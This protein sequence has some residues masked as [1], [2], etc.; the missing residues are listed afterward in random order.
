MWRRASAYLLDRVEPPRQLVIAITQASLAEERGTVREV[1]VR[2]LRQL[3][4]RRI[5]ES[6]GRGKIAVIDPAALRAM[7]GE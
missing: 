2:A 4:E 7:V 3:R 6:A 5:I 1:V